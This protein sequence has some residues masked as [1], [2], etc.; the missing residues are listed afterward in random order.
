MTDT[1]TF[2]LPLAQGGGMEG[3]TSLL[4]PLLGMFAIIYFL[5]IR[6]QQKRDKEKQEML[7]SL[8]KGDNVTTIGGVRGKI[9]RV[10]E[11]YVVLTVDENVK[12]EFAKSA[13]AQVRSEGKK[14]DEAE[15]E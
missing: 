13:I 4:L 11:E 1:A 12:I 9:A 14:K 8:S 5:M 2:L 3:M 6:P 10:A 15:D 7:A